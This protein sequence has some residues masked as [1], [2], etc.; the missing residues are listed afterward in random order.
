MV[1]RLANISHAVMTENYLY[2]DQPI[3]VTDALIGWEATQKFNI[4]FFND[5]ND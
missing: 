4:H 2:R 5:V 1:P 3:I